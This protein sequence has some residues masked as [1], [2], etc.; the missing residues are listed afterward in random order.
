[1]GW[2]DDLAIRVHTALA[3]VLNTVPRIITTICKFSSWR[4]CMHVHACMHA[5]VCACMHV[6]VCVSVCVVLMPLAFVSIYA[7]IHTYPHN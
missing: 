3:E 5:C 1:M 4:V 2:K 7:F 6:C